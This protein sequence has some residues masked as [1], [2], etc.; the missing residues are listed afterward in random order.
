MI[1]K[2]DLDDAPSRRFFHRFSTVFPMRRREE[3]PSH[4]FLFCDE[5][6]LGGLS[7]N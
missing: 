5:F 3:L 1:L 2:I 4:S 7:G 6:R